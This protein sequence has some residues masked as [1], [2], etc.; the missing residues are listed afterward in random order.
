MA[1]IFTRKWFWILLTSV[2]PV[3]WGVLAVTPEEDAAATATTAA[4]CERMG[5]RP[6][7]H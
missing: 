6:C 3:L 2:G 5:R 1:R 7:G 4:V